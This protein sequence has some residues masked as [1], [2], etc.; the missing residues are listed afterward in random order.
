MDLA[1]CKGMDTEMF[2]PTLGGDLAPAIRV[3]RECHVRVE[4]LEYA[5][6]RPELLGVW[7]GTSE[8]LR[9]HLRRERRKAS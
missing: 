8:K 7:A 6:V 9:R 2:F 3:C 4:C 5:V 1:R